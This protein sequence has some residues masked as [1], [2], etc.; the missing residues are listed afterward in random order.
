MVKAKFGEALRAKS[1]DGQVN[2]IL[3]KVLCHNVCV[4][5]QEMNELGI[6]IDFGGGKEV[7]TREWDIC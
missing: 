6:E 7:D 4:L 2:E 5:N 1:Y 3:L